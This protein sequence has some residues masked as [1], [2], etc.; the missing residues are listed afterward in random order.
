[1]QKPI[2]FPQNILLSHIIRFLHGEE[3]NFENIITLVGE[4]SI[5]HLVLTFSFLINWL[6]KHL[7]D[8]YTAEKYNDS[9]QSVVQIIGLIIQKVPPV[10]LYLELPENEIESADCSHW[11]ISELL[12]PI[13]QRIMRLRS[14][15][16]PNNTFHFHCFIP[17]IIYFKDGKKDKKSNKEQ[18]LRIEKNI[19]PNYEAQVLKY[20]KCLIMNHVPIQSFRFL[21]P[22]QQKRK[23]LTNVI[24]E[25]LEELNQTRDATHEKLLF[26]FSSIFLYVYALAFDNE[27]DGQILCGYIRARSFL[28]PFCLLGMIKY[29]I[30]YLYLFNLL[31]PKEF[32]EDSSENQENQ[33]IKR[34]QPYVFVDLTSDKTLTPLIQ[35]IP[36]ILLN[37]FLPKTMKKDSAAANNNNDALD[38][39]TKFYIYMHFSTVEFSIK[40]RNVL[41]TA[42]ERFLTPSH[43]YSM[44]LLLLRYVIFSLQ[45]TLV[46]FVSKDQ[47]TPNFSAFIKTVFSILSTTF[48]E[49]LASKFY[50]INNNEEGM[51]NATISGSFIHLLPLIFRS[52][53]IDSL[54]KFCLKAIKDD[55]IS[56]IGRIMITKILQCDYPKISPELVENIKETKDLITL[57]CY[58]DALTNF[59]MARNYKEANK[60]EQC[61]LTLLNQLIIGNTFNDESKSRTGNGNPEKPF[62]FRPFKALST[63]KRPFNIF[64]KSIIQASESP[65]QMQSM[66]E[67][68]SNISEEDQPWVIFYFSLTSCIE[69][70]NFSEAIT[71]KIVSGLESRDNKNQKSN[72]FVLGKNEHYYVIAQTLLGRLVS[73][74]YVKAAVRLSQA[75]ISYLS[76]DLAALHYITNF[77]AKYRPICPI[78]VLESFQQAVSTLPYSDEYYNLNHYSESTPLPIGLTNTVQ[79]NFV[80]KIF[81]ITK[82]LEENKCKIIQNPDVVNQEYQS[83]FQHALAF[84]I[85]NLGLTTSLQSD[86]I[87]GSVGIVNE[88]ADPTLNMMSNPMNSFDFDSP[89]SSSFYTPLMEFVSGFD[90]FNQSSTFESTPATPKV[91]TNQNE[92]VPAAVTDE[93]AEAL[94]S[95]VTCF[96]RVWDKREEAIK[97]CSLIATKM[98]DRIAMK[99]F[100]LIIKGN[101]NELYIQAGISFLLNANLNILEYAC[102]SLTNYI[103]DFN[104]NFSN[105]GNSN[106]TAKI[107]FFFKIL[108]PSVWRIQG[109]SRVGMIL[110]D[111]ILKSVTKQTPKKMFNTVIDIIS[112]V[113]LKLELYNNRAQIIESA[114]STGYSPEMIML[115]ESSLPISS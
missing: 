97:T 22:F 20:M 84:A 16:L 110:L 58:I 57:L 24:I 92:I 48:S 95:P 106:Y 42:K 89:Q 32:I 103:T 4:S 7:I 78:G 3:S 91:S 71:D 87:N 25:L 90:S 35:K 75:M 100:D 53:N 15:I 19:N 82:M 41:Y 94:L 112:Y 61:R 67:L 74:N 86:S 31:T 33:S 13:K 107:D 108:I 47:F 30:T 36:E 12:E 28:S 60:L 39:S 111:G 5:D 46:G 101:N 27:I 76:N 50:D 26:A 59:R 72:S 66:N 23:V 99:Y 88:M 69:N 81:S 98:D 6:P 80:N 14:Y 104:T 8:E 114:K 79:Q 56:R 83:P 96:T 29:I 18:L 49:P 115:I 65:S 10:I 93:I 113:Y 38:D 102:Q 77:L 37:Y 51:I 44:G 85:C 1:M 55:N 105:K 62:I 9:I 17:Q 64:S 45:R 43:V 68:L 2:D 11:L 54:V 52:F 40:M 21:P 109:E 63:I 70:E 34:P 73:F